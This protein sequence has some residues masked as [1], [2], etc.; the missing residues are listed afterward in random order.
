LLQVVFLCSELVELIFELIEGLGL[1]RR[2]IACSGSI[3]AH[4]AQC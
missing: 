3:G 4:F 2:E 1:A